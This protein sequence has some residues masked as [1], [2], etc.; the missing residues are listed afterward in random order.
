[1]T[2]MADPRECDVLIVGAGPTGLFLALVLARLGVRARIVDSAPEPGMTSR[3]LAVQAR[4]LE[5]YRQLGLA[6]DVVERGLVLGGVNLW[7]GGERRAHVDLSASGA[8]TSPFPFGVIFPQDEH[9]RLLI[10]RLAASGVQ[11]ERRTTIHS[12]EQ[13]P[14]GVV[15]RGTGPDGSPVELHAAFLAGCDGARS[16]ART[17]IGADFPG[18]TYE[19]LFYVADIVG[20]GPAMNRELH[21]MLDHA[22]FLGLFPMA[23]EGRARLIGTIRAEAEGSDNKL[24]WDD[25]DREPVDRIGLRVQRV[26]WFS[27]YR[28]HHRVANTF[29]RGKV[30][31]LGD[32][33]HIHSPVG[34]QGMNT[35]LGDAMNLAW[36]LAAVLAGRADRDLLDTYEPERIAFARRLVATT[37]RLFQAASSDGKLAEIVRTEIVPRLL[38]HVAST[39][40]GQRFFFAALSQTG[41]EYR[42]SAWS[43]GHAGGV[44]GGDRLPWVEPAASG[45]D[46]NFTPLESLDWQVHVY[47]AA[48][49]GV[50]RICRGRGVAL[51]TFAFGPPVE[52]ASLERDVVYLVRPDGYLGGV[53]GGGSLGRDLARYLELHGIRG[54]PVRQ[55]L[56]LGSR[57]TPELARHP[58]EQRRH[59]CPAPRDHQPALGCGHPRARS[60]PRPEPR[61]DEEEREAGPL[62]GRQ[63]QVALVSTLAT[64]EAPEI[65]HEADRRIR[66]A[67]GD[68]VGPERPFL[69]PHQGEGGRHGEGAEELQEPEIVAG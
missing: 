31:L 9:E 30:F 55:D 15:A 46:D 38:P 22:G 60:Q 56:E 12:I 49:E 5:L 48:P 43:T 39:H 68:E 36:K 3:A 50:D 53:F 23:G 34:G 20:Q 8:G 47:G 44:H 61:S 18:G 1:M 41:I 2:N 29:R 25:V 13:E 51:Q 35:G 65:Q 64:A 40:L 16:T 10:E 69:P 6:R 57:H 52:K 66:E 32:A 4:T 37:D 54:R 19:H 24:G 67:Q 14:G 11:V 58:E 45:G 42:E 59:L 28:V 21:I 17:A 27:T 7:K 63:P 62:R 33:A 26:H